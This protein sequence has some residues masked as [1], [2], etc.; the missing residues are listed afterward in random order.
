MASAGS[1]FV[2]L[3]LRDANYVQGLNRARQNTRGF[4][5]QAQGDLGKTQRAFSGV[6]SPVN[7]LGNAIAGLSGIIASALSVQKLVQYSD[8]WK[9][10]EGRLGLVVSQTQSMSGIQN[11]LA[12]IAE[13]TRQ[14]LEGVYNL[15]TRIAQA[16]PEA[17]RAQYDL[18][19]VTESINSALAITGEGSAQAA[20]AILQ[21]SQA[22]QS[23]F[24]ASSQE[25]NSLLDSAPRL[26]QALQRA[27]GDG[28]KSLKQLAADGDLSRDAVLRA[29]SGMGEEGQR[30]REELNKIPPTVGQAFTQ[31]NNAFL[32]YIGQ[33]EAANMS[34]SALGMGVKLLADNLDILANSAIILSSVFVA[35]MIPGIVAS[36]IKFAASTRQAILYQSALASMAGVSR[37]AAVSI[38]SLSGALAL[39]GGPLGAAFLAAGAA[40]Y[41]FT[42]QLSESE[43]VARDYQQS[44]SELE[45]LYGKL[46]FASSER[47][48]EIRKEIV[49]LYDLQVAELAA[50]EARLS[51]I[52]ASRE[53]LVG[54]ASSFVTEREKSLIATVEAQRKALRDFE[55]RALYL[56]NRDAPDSVAPR[57]QIDEKAAKKRLDELN[58]S[59]EKY[60]ALIKGIS[61]EQLNYQREEAELGELFKA[62]KITLDEYTTAL[63]GLDEKYDE[64][65][66]KADKTGVDMEQ[67]GKRAAENIQDAFADFLFD[68]FDQGLKGMAKGFIDTVR[69]MI[70]EAQAAQLAKALFGEMAGGS[71]GGIFGSLLGGLFGG[72]SGYNPANGPPPIKPSFA[73]AD[74]GS[75]GPGRWGIVGEEGPE[76]LYTGQSGAT[77]IPNKG[78]GGNTYN[79]DARGADQGAVV[80]LEQALLALAGPG[81]IEQRVNTAQSRGAL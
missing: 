69:K 9:Q 18:L 64:L 38:T 20:S 13:R 59:Y 56:N 29:L 33:S 42:T 40:V 44:S 72:G 8:T 4:A 27:V 61:Q 16:V 73:A 35:R 1:I 65:A 10:L 47:T 62:N 55:D 66:K 31:L 19:G 28:S 58:R 50:N 67:F 26:A 15:Y 79:I 21:F 48:K 45:G 63:F 71:G 14:P 37:I 3:L 53:G 51:S 23:D 30:L 12:D 78:M 80:R 5:G 70:A 11:E 34:T 43:K 57:V 54:R 74:G 41:Y 46:T 6:I 25:I 36:G 7:N 52:Q 76:L 77:I 39:V 81:V 60:E 24:K 75:F 49:A 68:P 32:Q 17:E 22:V 2:D